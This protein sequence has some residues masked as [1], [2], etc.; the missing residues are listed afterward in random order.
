MRKKTILISLIA[1]AGYATSAASQEGVKHI[2]QTDIQINGNCNIVVNVTNSNKATV[3]SSLQCPSKNKKEVDIESCYQESYTKYVELYPQGLV[4]FLLAPLMAVI[5]YAQKKNAESHA[6]QVYTSCMERHGYIMNGYG[7]YTFENGNRYEG[8]WKDGAFNGQGIF[9]WKGGGRYDGEWKDGLKSGNGFDLYSDGSTYEGEFE[10]GMRNGHGIM[11]W[12][13][14][15][16]YDGEWFHGDR[17][18]QGVS[19]SA[20]GEK[21]EGLWERGNLVQ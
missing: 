5:N 12:P 17:N 15:S 11:T 6:E 8:N 21:K 14:G 19:T 13:D 20:T 9:Y 3:D 16:R 18:G 4:S 10:N 1:L 2:V 7:I